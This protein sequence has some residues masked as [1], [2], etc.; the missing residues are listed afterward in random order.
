[1]LQGAN[2]TT[3]DAA[4]DLVQEVEQIHASVLAEANTTVNGSY[5]FGGYASQ[6]PPFSVAGPFVEGAPSPAT[7]F[8]GDP[9]EI[10]V[11]IDQGVSTTVTL[12][13]Q[14]VFMGD[15]D[16]DSNPDANR[17]DVFDLMADVRD[18]F[19]LP[20]DQR[21]D[22]LRATLDRIDTALDQLSIERSRVGALDT[23]LARQEDILADREVQLTETLS[24]AQDADAAEVFSDLVSQEA[25]LQASLAATAR[26]IQ[27][28]L[29]N[30]LGT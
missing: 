15:A 2:D 13:G 10:V 17:E 4:I 22:A 9:N 25:A 18:A 29:M 24:D 27:P 1:V 3:G 30:F 19:L 12:N 11:S 21:G 6:T 5:V 20:A 16:G 26:V 7:S 23:K 8:D 14:R 28:T